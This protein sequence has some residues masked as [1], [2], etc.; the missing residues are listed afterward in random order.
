[1]FKVGERIKYCRALDEEYSYGTIQELDDEIALVKCEGYYYGFVTVVPIRHLEK[2]EKRGENSESSKKHSKRSTT[3]TKLQG[4][5]KYK[6][7]TI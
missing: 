5:K 3:K 4:S 7:S 6:K 1:M 2:L